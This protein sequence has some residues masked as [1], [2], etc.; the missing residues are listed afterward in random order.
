[1]GSFCR[2]WPFTVRVAFGDKSLSAVKT[3]SRALRSMK[4]SSVKSPAT[5]RKSKM[6]KITRAGAHLDGTS[7]LLKNEF[8]D[9]TERPTA[10]LTRRRGSANCKC[11]KASL[12]NRLSRLAS[13]DLLYA[14][15]ISTSFCPRTPRKNDKYKKRV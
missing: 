12:E 3:A 8:I 6:T 4:S 11:H 5:K 15:F 7:R 14:D 13:N 10:E 2:V 9:C 1:M